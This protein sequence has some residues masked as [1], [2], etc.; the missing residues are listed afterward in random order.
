MRERLQKTKHTF[1]IGSGKGGVGKSLLS[2]NFG[3]HCSKKA[4]KTLIIDMDLGG[5]NLH[6]YLDF[7]PTPTRIDLWNPR[8][9]ES[10]LKT[11]SSTAF[12]GLD[13]IVGSDELLASQIES[14]SIELLV[15]EIMKLDYEVIIFDLGAGVGPETL[16]PFCAVDTPVLLST[17]EDTSIENAYFLLKKAFH[18]KLRQVSKELGYEQGIQEIINKPLKKFSTPSDLLKYIG[19]SEQF[20]GFNS[21]M[22]ELSPGILL[23]Q[24]R[25]FNEES[26]GPSMAQ[27]C[28]HYFGLDI[29]SVGLIQYDSSMWVASRKNKSKMMNYLDLKFC[30]QMSSVFQNLLKSVTFNPQ[31]NKIRA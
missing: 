18:F 31:R 10:I 24:V 19:G 30:G 27:V 25:S 4:Y 28:R 8:E 15:Y 17:P 20:P 23:N 26:I 9:P 16:I 1:A 13:I 21:K 2:S 5:A 29:I 11:I 6:T 7:R 12:P 3:I 14:A 22:K